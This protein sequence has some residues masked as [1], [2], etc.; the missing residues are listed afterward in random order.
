MM[1]FIIGIITLGFVVIVPVGHVGVKT[2]FGSVQGVLQQGAHLKAP[3]GIQQVTQ[4]DTR[5]QK[6]D[7][8][9][10]AGSKDLQ[11]IKTD[12]VV[13]Y[14]IDRKSADWVVQ[15]IGYGGMGDNAVEDRI[16]KPAV[17]EVVKSSVA[18]R[19]AEELLTK[20]TE[21]KN[22]IDLKLEKRLAGYRLVL[23]DVSIT[24]IDFSPEFNKAIEEKQVAEQESQK[25][26]YVANKAKKDAEAAVFRATGEAEAQRLQQQTLNADLLQKLWIEKWN[27]VL[28]SVVT[29]G[30]ALLQIPNR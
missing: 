22:D 7:V 24:N 12:I 28:P 17:S 13:N 29:D 4:V 20:R 15:N 2:Q 16:I 18:K 23:D 8:S 1:N 3:I 10:E 30:N 9:A 25:A 26:Q 11:T 6:I 19:N 27:G 5:V 14:H 21:L